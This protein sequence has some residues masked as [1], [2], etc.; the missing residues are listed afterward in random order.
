MRVDGGTI[1]G[2]VFLDNVSV[3]FYAAMVRDPD[4]HRRRIRVA[5]RYVQRALFR[6]RPRTS[7]HMPVPPRVVAPEQVLVALVSKQRVLPGRRARPG[8]ASPS[9]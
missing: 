5:A 3:G 2:Q 9:R 4:Y 1:N 8:A 6:G 7:L